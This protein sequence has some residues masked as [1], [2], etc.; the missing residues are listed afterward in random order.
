MGL[1]E[2]Q[3]QVPPVRDRLRRTGSSPRE[4]PLL[5]P[6]WLDFLAAVAWR[7]LLVVG[8]TVVVVWFASQ[9]EVV[10]IATVVALMVAGVLTPAIDWLVGRGIRR[11]LAPLIAFGGVMVIFGVLILFA[12]V[13]LI[14]D[15]PVIQ[16]G[17]QSA[18]TTIVDALNRGNVPIPAGTQADAQAVVTR[19]GASVGRTLGT[20]VLQRFS[21]LLS[22]GIGIFV[23]LGMSYRLL[24]SGDRLWEGL[25]GRVSVGRQEVYARL[26]RT[27]FL[28][29]GNYI[30]G[31]T[32]ISLVDAVFVAGAL[33]V[34]G[35][36]DSLGMVPIV[37]FA[38]FIPYIG[39]LIWGSLLVLV[40]IG[41]GDPYMGF[42]ALVVV[43]VLHMVERKF[44]T[45]VM[46]RRTRLGALEILYLVILLY[47]LGGVIAVFLALPLATAASA[48]W[49]EYRGIESFVEA[50]GPLGGVG[51]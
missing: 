9:I 51:P 4:F 31:Q 22:F 45:R 40:A 2:D 44:F 21:F 13:W 24:L 20:S 28:A 35:M 29:L 43:I 32:T 50:D 17:V 23:G 5:V 39:Y 30:W 34:M 19:G 16:K 6:P 42:V 33:V 15:W 48:M 49:G 47:Y 25:I 7:A 3:R 8:A 36:S 1:D 11:T 27:G 12:L 10:I 46:A 41:H 26:G 38:A 14:R 37:F 18:V